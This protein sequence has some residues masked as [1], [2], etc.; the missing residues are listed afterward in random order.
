MCHSP[1]AWLPPLDTLLAEGDAVSD[2][3]VA[4]DMPAETWLSRG[5][6]LILYVYFFALLVAGIATM[7]LVL[8]HGPGS[9]TSRAL[10]GG[11]GSGV[12]GAAAY[13][14]RKLYRMSLRRQLRMRVRGSTGA[15][16][17]AAER[18]AL[19]AYFLARP[20]LAAGF[21]VLLVQ[22]LLAGLLSIA[23]AP[24]RPDSGFVLAAMVLC[25]FV[26]TATGAIVDVLDERARANAQRF[27]GAN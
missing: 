25:F 23:V 2:S 19:V 22:G 17:D 12:F 14:L 16:A 15:E 24:A 6:L 10:L 20:I 3:P 1:A 27:F 8:D 13:Y 7:V 26:G 4:T 9:V 18:W 5:A 21:S 11:M